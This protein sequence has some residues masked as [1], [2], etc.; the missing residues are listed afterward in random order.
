MINLKEMKAGEISTYVSSL[1]KDDIDNSYYEEL[2]GLLKKD[3]RKAVKNLASRVSRFL[4]SKEKDIQRVKEMYEFDRKYSVETCLCGVDEVGRGPLAGPI[5]AASVILDLNYK[6]SKN[7]IL[8]INDSKKL[9]KKIREELDVVIK[10]RAL[11]YS[12]AEISNVE[13]DDKGIAWCNNEVLKRAVMGLSIK[14][15]L[16]LSDGYK[17][18]NCTINNEFIIRGDGKSASIACASII[19][20]VY[21]DNLMKKYA[22]EYPQYSFHKNSGY[23]TKEHI[24]AIKKYGYTPMH[25]ISFLKNIVYMF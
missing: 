16:V 11:S 2:V 25:R 14:P 9:T 19:A 6:N 7:L 1:L 24:E 5:V 12:I 10:E 21:R 15:Q 13:I 23:G 18:K 22:K 4:E 3:H 20:K 17:I 8:K